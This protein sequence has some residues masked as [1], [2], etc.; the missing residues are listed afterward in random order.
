MSAPA[1]PILYHQRDTYII[2]KP[3]RWACHKSRLVRDGPFLI[4]PLRK[5]LGGRVF[6]VH[7]LDRPTSG[8]LLVTTDRERVHVLQRAMADSAT[9]KTYL[10]LV[11]GYFESDAPVVVDTPIKTE[12]GM[13]EAESVVRCIG[14]SREPRCSLLVVTPKTGRH[15]QVRRHVRDLDHPVLGDTQHG[16][17]RE[18]KIW[19]E[20]GLTRL[21]LHCLS[22][23]LW[24]EGEHLASA[25]CPLPDDLT[26][27]FHE[28][29]WWPQ[30]VERMPA[31][32]EGQSRV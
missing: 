28:L 1:F 21:A 26:R 24:L 31:L 7:R 11:R 6:L 8:C 18:N 22:M 32:A 17:H 30:A 20:R 13:K 29:A 3:A 9:T 5:Q 14:R 2:A 10:T 19:K 27:V 12:N 4:G 16:D 25:T 15:H 23:D